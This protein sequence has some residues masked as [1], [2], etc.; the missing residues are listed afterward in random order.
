MFCQVMQK[1]YLGEVKNK[2]FDCL[3]NENS[4]AINYQNRGTMYRK[5]IANQRCVIFETVYWTDNTHWQV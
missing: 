3:L 2:S 4:S 1:H 5:V